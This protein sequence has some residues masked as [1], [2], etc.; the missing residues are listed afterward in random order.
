MITSYYIYVEIFTGYV[1]IFNTG[2]GINEIAF[3]ASS[4]AAQRVMIIPHCLMNPVRQ[5][6]RD[7]TGYVVK[8]LSR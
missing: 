6:S 7:Q 2:A 8:A 1:E 4:R 5:L 3:T